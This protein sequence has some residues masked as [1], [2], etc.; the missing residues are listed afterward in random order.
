MTHWINHPKS[1]DELTVTSDSYLGQPKALLIRA[2]STITQ[3][4]EFVLQPY[5]QTMLD[6]FCIVIADGIDA[7][8]TLTTDT[9]SAPN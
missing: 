1:N 7:G 3:K 5:P 4:K 8:R 9:T 6:Q 2:M